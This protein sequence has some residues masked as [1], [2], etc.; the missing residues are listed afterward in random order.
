MSP[1]T[2][3]LLTDPERI[4]LFSAALVLITLASTAAV[5]PIVDGARPFWRLF[6]L[7]P[8]PRAVAFALGPFVGV[9]L[10]G[11]L[12]GILDPPGIT[13]GVLGGLGGGG[14]SWFLTANHDKTHNQEP[15][16]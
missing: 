4:R 14:G 10:V 15:G 11:V 1:D 5:K 2:L 6:R 13:V 16:A 3:A 8:D 9:A 7:D 12:T